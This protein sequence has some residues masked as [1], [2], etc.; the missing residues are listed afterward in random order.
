MQIKTFGK[1]TEIVNKDFEIS[2]PKTVRALKSELETIFPDLAGLSY[3][4]AIDNEIINDE[5]QVIQHASVL[6]IMP[7]FSGG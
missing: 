2:F 5:H 1:I 4:I 3:T 6:A 7:P